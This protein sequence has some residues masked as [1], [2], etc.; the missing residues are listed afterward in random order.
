MLVINLLGEAGVGK[1]VTAAGL[2]YEL[3][4][5]NFKAEIVSE[6]AKEY[7]WESQKDKD[8]ILLP[9]PI[10]SQQVF[11]LGKQN[12]WLVRLVNKREIAIMECPLIMG[13]IYQEDQ[14]ENLK[15]FTPLV[16]EQFN[17]YNNVN[18]LLERNHEFD[19]QG[20]IHD[21]KGAAKVREKML[22]FLHK[23][24]IPYVKFKTHHNI[25][26]EIAAYIRDEYFPDRK[27][28]E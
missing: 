21:E 23:H 6:V 28:N 16:L 17:Q 18:I 3:S 8:G 4:I 13:A 20:R 5:N 15:Y 25:H 9:H 11:I 12:R 10:F 24:E 2:F 27:L 22:S 14:G 19:L 7:A 1:S 26:K